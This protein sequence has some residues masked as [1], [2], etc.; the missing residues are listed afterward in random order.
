M[1]TG[2]SRSS[3]RF[4]HVNVKLK[5]KWGRCARVLLHRNLVES[6]LCKGMH[7]SLEVTAGVARIRK[8]PI[9]DHVLSLKQSH[10][11]KLDYHM[12]LWDEVLKALGHG[13]ELDSV[14]ANSLA[15]STNSGSSDANFYMKKVKFKK[16]VSDTKSFAD[17]ITAVINEVAALTELVEHPNILSILYLRAAVREIHIFTE[18]AGI[19]IQQFLRQNESASDRCRVECR[20]LAHQ[21]LSGVDF[22]HEKGWAH[23]DLKSANVFICDGIVRIG[24]FGLAT[25]CKDPKTGETHLLSGRVGTPGYMPPEIVDGIDYCG[26]ASDLWSCGVLL[27]EI[28]LG[29]TAF[30]NDWLQTL[31]PFNF[32]GPLSIRDP[33]LYRIRVQRGLARVNRRVKNSGMDYCIYRSLLKL[34]PRLRRIPGGFTSLE[35]KSF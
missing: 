14:A 33:E 6:R 4:S 12:G 11:S 18:N 8:T 26:I 28:E 29:L 19:D 27:L 9:V 25:R 2:V 30:R 24:D 7:R 23:R 34:A 35:K 5:L 20:D 17:S 21:I 3:G 10:A 31:C 1:L 22:M 13:E 16:S 32:H 15:N